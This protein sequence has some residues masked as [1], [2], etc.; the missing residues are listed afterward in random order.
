MHSEIGVTVDWR[1]V[2][3]ESLSAIAVEADRLGFGYFWVPE[4]WGLE[5]FSI[6]G[7]LISLTKN[8]RFGSGVLNVYSRSPALIAMGYATLDQMSPGRFVLGLGSSGKGLI[9]NWHST[10]FEK[11]I[12]RT[13]E[14]VESIRLILSGKVADYK[15]E[16]LNLS[17]FRLFTKIPESEPEIYLAAMGEKSLKLAGEISDGAITTLYPISK[18]PDCAK[19]VRSADPSRTK[20]VFAYIPTEMIEKGSERSIAMARLAKYISFYVASM[21]KYYAQNLCSLG[22]RNDI[23]RI[24]SAHSSGSEGA[25]KAVSDA[26]IEEVCAIGSANEIGVKLSSLPEGVLPILGLSISSREELS[27]SMNTIRGIAR[28]G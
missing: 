3:V 25:S 8:I 21:G 6:I 19:T 5:A 4:A 17:R 11:P 14:Y 18:L 20:R 7:H 28:S 24:I 26:L 27:S 23:E 13:R 16:I 15:G 2:T 1:G 12:R 9:E 22:F 10:R